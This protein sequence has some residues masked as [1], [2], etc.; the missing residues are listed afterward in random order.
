[1]R[2][3]ALAW[4]VEDAMHIH[5]NVSTFGAPSSPAAAIGR[6]GRGRSVLRP[7]QH[8]DR[9]PLVHRAIALG[10]LRQRQL[11]VEDPARVDLPVPYEVDQHGQIAAHRGWTAVEV[12]VG[13]EQSLAVELDPV[14]NACSIASCVPTHSS[15]ES[16]LIPLVMSMIWATPSSPRSATTSVAPNSRASFCRD[17][18]RLIAMIRSAPICLAESTP[19]RPT[20]PSPTTT[21]VE[22]G[23]TLAASAANQPV[24]KTSEAVS[25]LGIRSAEGTPGVATKVPSASGTRSRGACAPPTPCRCMQDDW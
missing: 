10:D 2:S 6:R 22:P 12:N 8:L 7:E 5:Q 9:A 11:Q 15:T 3:A 16:A 25:R 18:F 23:F 13:E 21:T 24:P 14:R 19:R 17:A 20:A 4:P 1:M